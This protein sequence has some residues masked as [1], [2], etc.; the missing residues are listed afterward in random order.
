MPT[1]K[2]KPN[3]P[4]SRHHIGPD[5]SSISR[6]KPGAKNLIKGKK[7]SGG[8]NSHGRTTSRHRGGGHKRRYRTI[9]FRRDK[10]GIPAKVQ[11]IEYDPNRSAH[12]ALL[13]Y[14]DGE[15]RYIVAPN[16]LKVDDVIISGETAEPD[17]GNAMPI[18][19]MP[20]GTVI[21]NIELYPGH[22]AQLCRSAGT[23]AQLLAKTER[24]VTIELP[25]GETRMVLGDCMATV[26][27]ISNPDHFNVSLGKAGRNRWKGRR[28]QTRG[29]AMNPIDHPMGGGEG[30]A[31]GGH[32]RS[33]WGQSSKGKKTRKR[34][35]LS[36]RYIIR[37]RKKSK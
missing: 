33:P 37:N 26:G 3:T 18:K 23:S 4:G 9:D 31:S 32:P 21:H 30:K 17:V 36:N 34:K 12:V 28:P 24:Y 14:K 2:S 22:G 6:N 10:H 27:S 20:S 19:S 1:K 16:K 7:Q 11:T 5:Y 15:K 8:R 13:A 25:S 29:V 35:K